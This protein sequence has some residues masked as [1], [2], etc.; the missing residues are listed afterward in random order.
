MGEWEQWGNEKINT[1]ND[2]DD[3]VLMWH[4][5]ET[6]QLTMSWAHTWSAFLSKQRCWWRWAKKKKQFGSRLPTT[7]WSS[8]AVSN[9]NIHKIAAYRTHRR[10]W[11]IV[12]IIVQIEMTATVS[13]HQL[14]LLCKRLSTTNTLL[15]ENSTCGVHSCRHT[16]F[17]S[18][19]FLSNC[20]SWNLNLLVTTETE[21][22]CL[23]CD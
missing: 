3:D 16:F 15:Q 17:L 2:D 12:E 20:V 11:P 19:P 13:D 18:L 9:Q 1:D 6:R 23:D 7:N 21:D 14:V 10:E 5:N 8:N 22:R 4:V